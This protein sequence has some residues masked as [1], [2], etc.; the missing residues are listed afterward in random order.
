M[1]KEAIMDKASNTDWNKFLI[2][3]DGL[4]VHPDLL[5]LNYKELF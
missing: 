3:E 5:N 4:F 1:Q 2:R